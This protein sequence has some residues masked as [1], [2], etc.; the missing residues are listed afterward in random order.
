LNCTHYDPRAYNGCREPHAERV[1]DK[2]RSNFCDFF[3]YAPLSEAPQA[4]RGKKKPSLSKLDD[5][6]K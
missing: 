4:S 6:F 5:L 1:L 2:D 3:A